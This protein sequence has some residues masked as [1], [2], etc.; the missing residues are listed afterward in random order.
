[1]N[2]PIK[3]AAPGA[4]CTVELIRKGGNWPYEGQA[5]DKL[6]IEAAALAVEAG[7]GH[8]GEGPDS[9][10]PDKSHAH[11]NILLSN[12][13]M[14]RALNSQFRGMDK[15]TNVLSFPYGESDPANPE[16]AGM[17]GDV[18]LAFETVEREARMRDIPLAHHVAHLVVHGALQLFGY[19]HGQDDE[20][21]EMEKLEISILAELNIPDPYIDPEFE[22]TNNEDVSQLV[23]G[24]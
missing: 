19:D 11:I 21:D 24:E 4:R 10:S 3:D 8:E 23:P 2:Q 1:M 20:A 9:V 14:I 13:E 18:I 12:D 7:I 5:L 15:A 17:L 6:I 22:R 16:E